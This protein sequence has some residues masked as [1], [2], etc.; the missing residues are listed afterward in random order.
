MTLKRVKGRVKIVGINSTFTINPSLSILPHISQ[1][2]FTL[3]YLAWKKVT[4][5]GIL[6]PPLFSSLY[7]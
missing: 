2:D 5:K 6:D 3:W 4:W 1:K 7:L